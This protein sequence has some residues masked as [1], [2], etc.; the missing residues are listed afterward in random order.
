MPADADSKLVMQFSRLKVFPN[1]NGEQTSPTVL[2]FEARIQ[3]S[4]K[5]HGGECQR[6]LDPQ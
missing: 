3:F 4:V 5:T 2:R 1:A 6:V